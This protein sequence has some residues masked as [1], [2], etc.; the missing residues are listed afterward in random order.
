ML[1]Y[2]FVFPPK[3]TSERRPL[4]S[5]R[6]HRHQGSS[7][8]APHRPPDAG[9][10][11]DQ[12]QRGQQRATGSLSFL[13]FCAFTRVVVSPDQFARYSQGSSKNWSLSNLILGQI[14]KYLGFRTIWAIYLYFLSWFEASTF[15]SLYYALLF[16]QYFGKVM[17]SCACVWWDQCYWPCVGAI[18]ESFNPSCNPITCADDVQPVLPT[19]ERIKTAAFIFEKRFAKNGT[20]KYR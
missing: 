17:C 5:E 11:V 1:P 14:Y 4:H 6:H 2:G 7:L 16:A 10:A 8:S 15:R 20:T 12:E 13:S 18:S 3:G 9:E 19:T